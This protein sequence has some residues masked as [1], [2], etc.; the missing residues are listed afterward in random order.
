MIGA[1]RGID[2]QRECGNKDGVRL[3]RIAARM[4]SSSSRLMCD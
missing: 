2:S 3:P 1:S 4:R